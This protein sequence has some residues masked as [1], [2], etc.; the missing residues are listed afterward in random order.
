MGITDECNRRRANG[1][2]DAVC[3][4]KQKQKDGRDMQMQMKQEKK[5]Q[6]ERTGSQGHPLNENQQ[7]STT[8]AP[9]PNARTPR[10][11]TRTQSI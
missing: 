9:T 5:R 4:A 8:N 6:E 3:R 10:S 2:D 1:D 7:R 11:P